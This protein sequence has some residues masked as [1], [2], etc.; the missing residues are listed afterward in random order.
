M[1]VRAKKLDKKAQGQY[2]GGAGT[3]VLVRSTA[4]WDRQHA[5]PS[6]RFPWTSATRE[7]PIA[8]NAPCSMPPS[9]CFPGRAHSTST[10][11]WP[12]PTSWI[13]Q[14]CARYPGCVLLFERLR[15]IRPKGASKSQ[16]MN[17]KQ[18]NQL[19]G[20]INHHAREKA[21]TTGTVTAEVNPHGTSQYCARYRV[22][23][24]SLSEGH[25]AKD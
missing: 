10:S 25:P 15:K 9:R 17:R 23:G 24:R 14:V 4:Q 18:A 5:P 19:R 7:E 1:D 20:K 8:K 2:T 11:S 12:M 6:S 13:V 22:E 16:R 21:C 3:F